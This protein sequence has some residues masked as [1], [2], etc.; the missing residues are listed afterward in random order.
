MYVLVI[1]LSGELVHLRLNPMVST[2]I[3]GHNLEFR[4]NMGRITRPCGFSSKPSIFKR[5]MKDSLMDGGR[6]V[7]P[8]DIFLLSEILLMTDI[9]S[10]QVVVY[11]SGNLFGTFFWRAAC[12]PLDIANCET[13]HP[14]DECRDH[15]T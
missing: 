6:P 12:S 7:S 14:L 5:R 4:Q 1:Y 11:L 10:C 2:D 8:E 15:A 3:S 13:F 9:A